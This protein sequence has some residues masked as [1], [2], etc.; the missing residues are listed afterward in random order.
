M[1]TSEFNNIKIAGISCALP[2]RRVVNRE[3]YSERFGGEAVRK[4]SELTGIYESYVT[5]EYQTV[6]DLCYEASVRLLREKNIDPQTIDVL[7]FCSYN[8]DYVG[9]STAYVLQHRLAM[10]HDCIVFD[11]P[12]GCSGFVYGLHA[13]SS[14]L[15]SSSARRGLVLVGD[16]TSKFASPMDKNRMLFGDAG[17]AVLVEKSENQ[18]VMRAAFRNDG[19]RY[20]AIITPAGADRKF[21]GASR[22]RVMQADG[23]IRSD[24]D[25]AMNGMEVFNFAI[26]DAPKLILEFMKY[27]NYSSGD[28]DYLLL[29]QA[30][31]FIMK[32][33]A[34]KVKFPMEKV[35]VSLDRYGNSS[36]TTIPVTI[37][38]AFAGKEPRHIRALMS[39]FG[40]GLSWGVSTLDFDTADVLPIFHTDAYYKEA[41]FRHDF[42]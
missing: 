32:H 1:I 36:G 25:T 22:E 33:L 6:S 10:K 31:L 5:S 7:L 17:A 35:P 24:Y 38:D 23:N 4:S 13:A 14:I 42:T 21:E 2:T 29:H 39:G 20:R 8:R 28:F 40:V 26:T 15:S 16:S 27:Y 3:E 11:I 37:C 9:P 19:S 30:N 34:K 41:V 18:P 12:I